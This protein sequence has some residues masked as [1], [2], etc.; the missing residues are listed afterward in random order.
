MVPLL[1]M[2]SGII[3]PAFSSE[4]KV[5]FEGLRNSKGKI[6]YL[7]FKNEK[8]FPDDA[9]KSIFQGEILAS[10][11]S[12]GISLNLDEGNYAMTLIHDENENGKLDKNFIGIPK[13][14]FG[15][16]NNPL[17]LFGPPSFAKAVF[18]L[19]GETFINIKV[20]YF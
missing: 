7:L 18:K 19:E 16:S 11:A 15:F 9:T 3:T 4:L 13:E 14:G 2:L 10:E 17:I 1:L 6:L 20:K 12:A 8:G 5:S